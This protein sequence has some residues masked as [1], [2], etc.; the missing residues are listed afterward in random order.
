M[1]ANI[2][3]FYALP[4]PESFRQEI[5]ERFITAKHLPVKWT[6]PENL[7]ITVAF[8]GSVDRKDLPG[9][10]SRGRDAIQ[11]IPAFSLPYTGT[12]I[13]RN[14]GK[15]VMIWSTYA[16]NLPFLNL[17][18]EL[19]RVLNLRPHPAPAPHT[20]LTRIKKPVELPPGLTDG[21]S[22]SLRE[23][24]VRS[25]VLYESLLRAEGPEY[26]TLITLPLVAS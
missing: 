11:N 2:R 15:P 20:T 18:R 19:H 8:I 25:I 13:I 5:Q 9:I 3:L 14:K 22:I 16:A 21:L 12:Q 4:L 1:M 7:H 10:I 6:P 24:P 23:I 17:Y 26:R